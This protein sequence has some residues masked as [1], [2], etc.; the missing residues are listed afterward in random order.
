MYHLFGE[1]SWSSLSLG[2]AE[3]Q[4]CSRDKHIPKLYSS[5][6]NMDP[7]PIPSELQVGNNITVML[8][9]VTDVFLLTI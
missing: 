7:G 3:C 8:S 1:L 6:N 2:S 9:Y 4:R 5:A